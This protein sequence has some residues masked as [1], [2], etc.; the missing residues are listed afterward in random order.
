MRGGA[1]PARWRTATHWEWDMRHAQRLV[2]ERYFGIPSE[3]CSLA[4]VRNDDAK[5]VQFAASPGILPPLLFDLRS[6]PGHTNNLAGAP[7]GPGHERLELAMAQEMLRWRMRNLD[8]T[9]SNCYLA[10]EVGPVWARDEW[11]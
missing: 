9:L 7:S 2:A 11:R 10:P 3:H 1:A 8:R 5:Y 4:V 6:D